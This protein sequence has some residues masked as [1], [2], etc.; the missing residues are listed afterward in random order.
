MGEDPS[1]G[2]ISELNALGLFFVVGFWFGL[3]FFVVCVFL[4]LFVCFSHET[5]SLTPR[6]GELAAICPQVLR[7][8]GL[9]GVPSSSVPLQMQSRWVWSSWPQLCSQPCGPA[10]VK[11]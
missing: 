9:E 5:V 1:L 6:K 7:K 10:M 3:G 11:V 2:Q 8:P 4:V